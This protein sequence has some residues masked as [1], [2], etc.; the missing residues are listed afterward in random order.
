MALR[1]A[2]VDEA[3][4]ARLA[5]ASRTRSDASAIERCTW[6]VLAEGAAPERVDG[7]VLPDD[8]SNKYRQIVAL[9]AKLAG[10]QVYSESFVRA[11]LTG[12]LDLERADGVFLDDEPASLVYAAVKRVLD[13]AGAL[14]LGVFALLPVT[15]ACLALIRLETPGKALLVQPRKGQ[16]GKVFGML[17]LRTMREE[18]HGSG[19]APMASDARIT[20]V[21]RW[22]RRSRFDELPQLWNVLR[23]EMSLI[24]PRPE[25]T[26]TAEALEAEIPQFAFRYLVRPGITGWAQVHQGHVT[27]ADAARVKLEYDLYYAKNMSLALD[28]AI[29]GNDSS[30][31]NDWPGRQVNTLLH[32]P[33][34]QPHPAWLSREHDPPGP[35]TLV[36]LSTWNGEAYVEEQMASILR[37]HIVGS[38]R[39]LV[40]D[41]GSN[42]RTLEKLRTID[43][44]R[45]HLWPGANVGTKRSYFAL[46][47]A[48][49][50]LPGDFLA[51]ADQDDVWLPAKV[52]SAIRALGRYEQPALYCSAVTLVDSNLIP[53]RKYSYP[54]KV[55]FSSLLVSNC[56]TGCTVVMN[57]R[58]VQD[59]APLPVAE[60]V[61]MHDWWCALVASAIGIIVYDAESHILY[62]QHATN[63]IGLPTGEGTLTRLR[64]GWRARAGGPTRILQALALLAIYAPVLTAEQ[65]GF[66][67][68]FVA[69]QQSVLARFRFA[70]FHWPAAGLLGRLA[71]VKGR[72]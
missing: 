46:L 43:D 58:L 42:D 3:L 11:L 60:H 41:D 67:R 40:R 64:R 32:A 18:P 34:P 5:P 45:I 69:G 4:L 29:G 30:D 50:L 36:V 65:M 28:L 14:L 37:Q 31:G 44:P 15:L 51:F 62:R 47:T 21:G 16:R 1:L 71:F 66:L 49:R 7:V 59:L 56:A 38:L 10:V 20:R 53:I 54:N 48:A 57:R 23:G 12:R 2:V 19:T 22:L 9:R 13:I 55:G 72:H 35:R 39:V 26:R 70:A 63:Q 27:A 25:W 8:A 68:R 17:K 52:A 24:G 61:W 6:V 33:M